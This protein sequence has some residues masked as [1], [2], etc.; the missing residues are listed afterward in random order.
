MGII[1]FELIGPRGGELAE[2]AG[3]VT[4]SAVGIDPDGAA[5]FDSDSLD[6]AELEAVIVDALGGIDS[7]WSSQ[8]RVSE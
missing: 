4:E 2:E 7:D 1:T 3:R 8:L 6:G 5:T